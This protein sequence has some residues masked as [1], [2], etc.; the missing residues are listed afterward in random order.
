ML[1][2]ALAFAPLLLIALGFLA[3]PWGLPVLSWLVGNPVGRVVAV[4]GIAV[5]AIWIAY[6]IGRKD[7][8]DRIRLQQAQHNL[9]A[10]RDRVSTDEEI[11]KMPPNRRREELARW[12]R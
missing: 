10:L 12:V 4:V 9:D 3:T 1:K 11:R 2:L 8:V 6:Q 5:T 7:G